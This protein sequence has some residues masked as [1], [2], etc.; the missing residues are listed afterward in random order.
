MYDLHLSIAQADLV[1]FEFCLCCADIDVNRKWAHG[2][3]PLHFA[4]AGYARHARGY[5]AKSAAQAQIY[6]R[7]CQI[8]LEQGADPLQCDERTQNPAAV[9]E[10]FTPPSL[11]AW[12][13]RK[14]EAGDFDEE[15]ETGALLPCLVTREQVKR[16]RGSTRGV[17]HLAVK[18]SPDNRRDW[19][20][21]WG[22]F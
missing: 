5:S 19:R 15:L 12:L 7:M 17:G 13:A 9:G 3:T 4:V 1:F 10:G 11:R 16:R 18:I 14:A 8:L 22:L 20:T 2:W 21:S 6:D